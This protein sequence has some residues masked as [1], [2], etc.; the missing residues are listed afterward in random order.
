M[1]HSYGSYSSGLISPVRV[2]VYLNGASAGAAGRRV[3]LDRGESLAENLQKIATKL[4]FEKRCTKPRLY[5]KSG[6]EVDDVDEVIEGEVLFFEPNGLMFQTPGTGSMGST[7]GGG[8]PRGGSRRK[9]IETGSLSSYG[10][11]SAESQGNRANQQ[12][13]YVGKGGSAQYSR[14]TTGTFSEVN[15]PKAATVPRNACL[16]RGNSFEYDYLFKF[17]LVGSVAVGKSCILLRFTDQRFRPSHETTIGVDFGTETIR[18]R[19]NQRIKLQIWDTAGQEYFKAITRA[20]FREAAAAIIVYDVSNR[21]SFDDLKQWLDNVRN[22]STNRSLTITLVGNKCDKTSAERVVSEKEGEQFARENGL[23]FLEASALSGE[24]IQ[25]LFA[26]TADAVLRKVDSGIIDL[27][28][29]SQGV[30]RGEFNI[31]Q[32]AMNNNLHPS[33]TNYNLTVDGNNLGHE[34]A[35]DGCYC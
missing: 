33:S 29:P 35:D 28:D 34:N 23:L 22:A 20:Y 11:T 25:E 9:S 10:S 14:T 19:G 4:N 2:S 8:V 3:V 13:Q 5:T 26:R 24:N 27:D 21:Q 6:I 15:Q 17:I 12:Q 1:S 16:A 31:D 18:V 32:L 30:R 7:G